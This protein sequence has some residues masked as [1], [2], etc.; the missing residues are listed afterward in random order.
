MGS[1][2]SGLDAEIF[3]QFYENLVV[4]CTLARSSILFCNRY[5]DHI[6][7]T[8]DNRKKTAANPL[9]TK[10]RLLCLK[11]DPVRTAQ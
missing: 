6:L 2:I 5:V 4:K 11:T 9:K 1:R 10:P 8:F 7:L 3:L